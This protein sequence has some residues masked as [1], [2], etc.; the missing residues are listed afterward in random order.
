MDEDQVQYDY[1]K[2]CAAFYATQGAD[3]HEL[4]WDA[5]TRMEAI[6]MDIVEKNKLDK[7]ESNDGRPDPLPVSGGGQ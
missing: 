6:G 5:I 1:W 3:T 2:I 4:F 7:K